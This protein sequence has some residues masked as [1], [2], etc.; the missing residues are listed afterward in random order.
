MGPFIS[1]ATQMLANATNQFIHSTGFKYL[2]VTN[3]K[4]GF[5]K[6]KKALE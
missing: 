4:R 3:A 2:V 5:E 6:L 1:Q